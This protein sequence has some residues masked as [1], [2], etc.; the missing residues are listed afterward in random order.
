[1]DTH[2]G[3]PGDR[4][5]TWSSRGPVEPWWERR[6]ADDL[7][8][9]ELSVSERRRF[10]EITHSLRLLRWTKGRWSSIPIG[11]VGCVLGAVVG[12]V[13]MF[14]SLGRLPTPVSFAGY[15]LTLAA[16]ARYADLR[17]GPRRS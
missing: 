12:T 16:V 8:V 17:A 7:P 10:A 2:D 1:M 14:G 11:P 3:R 4:R 15:L 13:V 5:H 9:V 6:A